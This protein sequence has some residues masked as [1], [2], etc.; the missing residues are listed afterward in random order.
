MSRKCSQKKNSLLPKLKLAWLKSRGAKMQ[1]QRSV[2]S[3]LSFNKKYSIDAVMTLE[4]AEL[5]MRAIAEKW[6]LC[7]NRIGILTKL[8]SYKVW[9]CKVKTKTNTAWKVSV[10]SPNAWKYGTEKLQIQTLFTQNK[11]MIDVI[12][13]FRFQKMSTKT[14]A[15][16]KICGQ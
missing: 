12:Q 2:S 11:A 8:L 1:F 13:R 10:F 16:P 5:I 14:F 3:N 6:S 7:Q 15:A 9:Q 4:L